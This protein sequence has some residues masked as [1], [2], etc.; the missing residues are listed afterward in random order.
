MLNLLKDG[1]RTTKDFELFFSSFA[2]KILTCLYNSAIADTKIKVNSFVAAKT[3]VL[4]YIF[5]G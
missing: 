1:I 5:V 2:F 3:S 4:K